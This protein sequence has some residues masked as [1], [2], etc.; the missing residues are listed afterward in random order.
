VPALK[1]AAYTRIRNGEIEKA[2]ALYDRLLAIVPE[3]AD[4]GYNY[5]LVLFAMKK[6][7]ESEQILKNH[8]FALLDNNDVLLLYARCQKEQ[9]KPEAI[10]TYAQY[11][12]NNND[13]KV[14][15]E[16]GQILEKGELYA[17]ALAEYRTAFTDL[18]A[19]SA[20]PSKPELRFA[21]ARV[22][23]I[24]DPTNAEGMTEL[25]GAVDEGF[26]DIE[27]LEGLLTN[28]KISAANK[29]SIRTMVT[30]MK[31]A[32]AAAKAAAEAAAEAARNDS[33]QGAET[34]DGDSGDNAVDTGK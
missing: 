3:S 9:D 7:A 11:L 34:E 26:D 13:A 24:A 19:G 4:D 23:M 15:Y 22:L 6:Y 18:P 12:I 33:E 25:K 29:E 16:Y 30:E 10:D 32:E 31:A 27:A 14:R 2:A 21:I 17:R 28:D 5:A 20:N 1:A 8:E